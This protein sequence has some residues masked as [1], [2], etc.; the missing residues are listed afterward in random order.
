LLEL[1]LEQGPIGKD[2]AAAALREWATQHGV[3]G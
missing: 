1:R 2:A 3:G